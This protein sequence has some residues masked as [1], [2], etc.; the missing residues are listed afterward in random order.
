M[1]RKAVICY[2]QAATR[3]ECSENL[4]QHRLILLKVMVRIHHQAGGQRARRESG[5]ANVTFHD[6]HIPE[7]VCL[8][9]LMQPLDRVVGYIFRENFP[10][11]SDQIGHPLN[12]I[13][14]SR[15]DIRNPISLGDFQ[16]SQDIG[17]PLI[18]FS[19]LSSS[20]RS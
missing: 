7:I 9:S 10:R 5:I 4:L 6:F 2:D 19:I 16:R 13:A 11:R 12:V 8:H 17:C 15:S 1:C 3:F 14:V 18:S 20:L